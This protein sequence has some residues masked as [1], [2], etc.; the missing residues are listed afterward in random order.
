MRQAVRVV[1]IEGGVA[2][3]I[4]PEGH[5]VAPSLT[6]QAAREGLP[7]AFRDVTDSDKPCYTVKVVGP[8]P[9]LSRALDRGSEYLLGGC[10]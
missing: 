2:I 8:C 1:P 4:G 7:V 9:M 5:V 3:G 10:G 6:L